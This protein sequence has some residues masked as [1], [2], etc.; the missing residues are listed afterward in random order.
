MGSHVDSCDSC[1]HIS[2][3]YNSCRNR[4]CPICQGSKQ[5]EWVESQLA[6]LLPVPYSHVVF[7]IPQELNIIA[8]QNQ[9]LIYSILIKSAGNTITELAKDPKYL[10]ANTGVT[11]VL[12]T[13]GQNLSFHPHVHC[14]VP[15]GG[16]SL[17]SLKFVRS[18]KKF[19]LPVKVLSRKFRGK[20]LFHLKEAWN[21]GKIKLFNDALEL[22][23]ENQFLSLVDKL[24][25]LEWVA[26]CKKPFK[27]PWHMVKYLGRYTS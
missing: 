23:Q 5:H 18:S 7:T 11:S 1:S 13:W 19:F 9:E 20:F 3:S 15:G 12:H 24:Y 8:L 21:A 10:G 16:L 25:Q 4:H 17:D 6:K 27:S 26:H 2:I 14:I 22:G